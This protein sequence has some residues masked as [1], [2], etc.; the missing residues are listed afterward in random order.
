MYQR[1][2]K[3][4]WALSILSGAC[5]CLSFEKFNIFFLSFFFPII[6]NWLSFQKH[7]LKKHFLLGFVTSLT[8]MVGGFYWVTYVIHEFGY[9]PWVFSFLIFLLF[10]GF[11]ALNFPIFFTLAA[12]CHKNLVGQNKGRMFW[13]LWFSLFLP[14]LFTIVEYSFPKLFPWYLGQCLYRA[15]G[16]IQIVEITGSIFLSFLIY[17][18]GS[19]VGLLIL[20]PIKLSKRPWGVLLIP[21]TLCFFSLAFSQYRIKNPP[22]P[23]RTLRVALVQANIGSL[24]KMQ[25]EQG[26]GSLV[27]QVTQKY[28]ALTEEALKASPPPDLILWPETAMPFS[29]GATQKRFELLK[30]QVALWKT[31]LITGSYAKSERHSFRDYN[32]AF[33]LEPQVDGS[34]KVQSYMKNILLAF[35]EYFPFGDYFPILYRYFPQVADFEKGITQDPVILNDGTALGITICYEA[36]VP[37]FFRKTVSHPV[38]GVVNLT[39]DSWFGPTSEPFLHGSLT[40]FR[41]LETKIPFFRVTN[42]GISFAVDSLGNQSHTSSVNSAEVLQVAL[43]LP[44]NPVP[45]FYMKHGDWFVLLS[46]GIVGLFL[47]SLF[48]RRN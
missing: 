11:G 32:G 15:T 34:I 6:L 25:S 48:Y 31:P 47:F 33:L 4:S 42:T 14:A 17:S 30:Q 24:E 9:V 16:V 3:K 45:T 22:A 23:G 7:S 12:Y 18:L 46:F 26:L 39:N 20:P 29:M 19:A 27:D 36:I 28:Y 21:L 43:T 41:S 38:H 44:A 1:L 35:G 5:V 37:S 40:V 10:C 8:L 13:S 2:F